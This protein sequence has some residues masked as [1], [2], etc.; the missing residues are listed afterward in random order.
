MASLD[1][2]TKNLWLDTLSEKKGEWVLFGINSQ[3]TP[4][5]DRMNGM[6]GLIDWY[7]HGQVSRLISKN[8]MSGDFCLFPTE[9]NEKPNFLLYH[10]TGSPDAKKVL[11]KLKSLNIKQVLMAKSTFPEDFY[12]KLKQN[13]DKDGIQ[14]TKLEP[15]PK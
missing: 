13:L 1:I 15:D 10:Y 8:S 4:L 5:C 11:E 6:A 9:T 7:I 12:K 3:I 14:W 2:Q